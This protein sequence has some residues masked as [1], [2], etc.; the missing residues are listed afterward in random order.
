MARDGMATL[1]GRVRALTGAG[2]A[3]YSV[4]G[5]DYWTNDQLQ[6]V[7][8]GNVIAVRG[9]LLAWFPETIE[10]GMVEYHDCASHYR[11]F[12]EAES[13]T[14]RWC[15]R[16]GTGADAGTAN[17]TAN[18]RNGLIRFTGDT[19]GSSVY[20]TAYSFDVNAAAADVWAE[21]LAHFQ[22]WYD[23]SAD[24][25]QFSRAQAFAHASEMEKLLR[26]RAGANRGSGG[27]VRI[28]AF[29][30]TDLNRRR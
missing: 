15:L 25:K 13:G 7:L 9:E 3:E 26:S 22:A 16:D 12:E 17:Y 21:R 27:D 14:A 24:G 23:F 19:A 11:D 10:G 4:A 28:G 20:L 18:Y 2:T 6:A 30:R 1:I 5:T 29:V 8:D